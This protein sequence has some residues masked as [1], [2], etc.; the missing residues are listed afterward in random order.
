MSNIKK[1]TKNLAFVSE[2]LHPSQDFVMIYS[3]YQQLNNKTTQDKCQMFT[4]L[5]SDVSVNILTPAQLV[6]KYTFRESEESQRRG[7][8]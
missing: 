7:S 5:D 1:Q 4:L 8:R 3:Y 6:Q 2:T